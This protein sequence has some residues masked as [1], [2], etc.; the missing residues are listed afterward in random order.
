MKGRQSG[1][2]KNN[3]KYGQI[4]ILHPSRTSG[5]L[6]Q[7]LRRT[8]KYL[9]KYNF[10]ITLVAQDN[11]FQVLD[12]VTIVT[13]PSLSSI[14]Y[15]FVKKVL[16]LIKKV[17]RDKKQEA[18]YLNKFQPVDVSIPFLNDSWL[19]EIGALF[20]SFEYSISI[21]LWLLYNKLRGRFRQP[22]IW[23]Y[24]RAGAFVGAFVNYFFKH[25]FI[26][27]FQGTVL[28]PWLKS[29]GKLKTFFRLPFDYIATSIKSDLVIMTHDGTKGDEVLRMLGHD[30]N[31][32]LFLKNG[33]D[34]TEILPFRSLKNNLLKS[35]NSSHTFVVAYRIDGWKRVERAIYLAACLKK[36][37][38]V[39]KLKIIGTG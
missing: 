5:T 26:T 1:I 8:L 24:E 15:K 33:I 7:S 13:I 23:G 32:I 39:F 17:F 27:S 20:K 21:F 16:S 12:G 25:T 3:S 38:M 34:E 6:N 22:I 14:V 18:I 29:K 28:Y 36:K 2:S 37:G 35:D 30:P 9:V 19:H 11:I 4:I 31:R 10:K